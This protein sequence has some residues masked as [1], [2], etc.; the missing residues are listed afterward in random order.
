MTRTVGAGGEV[1]EVVARGVRWAVV[2][3]LSCLSLLVTD[4]WMSVCAF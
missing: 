4:A 1:G 2:G 3:V